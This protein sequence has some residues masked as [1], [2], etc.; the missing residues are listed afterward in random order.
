MDKI[1]DFIITKLKEISNIY[2][3]LEIEFGRSDLFQNYTIY[4]ND[5]EIYNSESFMDYEGK[6][7]IEFI[8][9]FNSDYS[10]FFTDEK[11]YFDVDEILYEKKNELESI[12][13]LLEN[14]CLE[15]DFIYKRNNYLDFFNNII[16][17]D[18]TNKDILHCDKTIYNE[19]FETFIKKDNNFHKI[20]S[21]I[22]NDVFINKSNCLDKIINKE[23]FD[24]KSFEFM[25][26]FNDTILNDPIVNDINY[27]RTKVSYNSLTKS[28]LE[29]ISDGNEEYALAA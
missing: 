21:F 16:C 10:L 13:Q 17:N 27:E 6:I 9:T 19:V 11:K 15:E 2:P 1:K 23:L 18:R 26:F 14:V 24:N 20:N 5:S 28:T 4:V 22:L 25:H 7:I 3:K 8:N 12:N 29:H